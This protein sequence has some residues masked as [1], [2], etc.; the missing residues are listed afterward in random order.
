MYNLKLDRVSLRFIFISVLSI[1]THPL[2]AQQMI[3]SIKP[4]K[5]QE[6]LLKEN[7]NDKRDLN[8]TPQRDLNN[9]NQ[10]KQKAEDAI[11]ASD[12]IEIT[13]PIESNPTQ[14]QQQKNNDSP[15]DFDNQHPNRG[16]QQHY[17]QTPPANYL[18][19][20]GIRNQHLRNTRKK[21]NPPQMN[22]NNRGTQHELKSNDNH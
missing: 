15:P 17:K 3:D 18:K 19:Q 11:P 7:E 9:D 16:E 21:N 13:R 14:K 22:K 1:S 10:P 6:Q 20:K 2:K 4:D 12:N 8:T 5:N